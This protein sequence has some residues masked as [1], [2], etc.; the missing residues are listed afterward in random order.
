MHPFTNLIFSDTPCGTFP[1][2]CTCAPCQCL[3]ILGMILFS[4]V[5]G[6]HP[7]KP[8]IKAPSPESGGFLPLLPAPRAQKA[9]RARGKKAQSEIS[10]LERTLFT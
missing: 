4:S 8:Q 7:P 3:D 2:S 10:T 9:E 6:G 5:G 1:Y